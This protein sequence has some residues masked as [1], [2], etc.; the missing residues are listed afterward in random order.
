MFVLC[1]ILPILLLFWDR[2]IQYY[3]VCRER[4]S[5]Y[6]HSSDLSR[7]SWGGDLLRLTTIW[8]HYTTVLC[9]NWPCINPDPVEE[10]RGK[11]KINHW[12]KNIQRNP[13]PLQKRNTEKRWMEDTNK[14]YGTTNGKR[15]RN[16]CTRLTCTPTHTDTVNVILRC[17][18]TH[19]GKGKCNV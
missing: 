4:W 16:V 8:N 1:P 12:L 7:T 18:S 3:R 10:Y 17:I 11:Q 15:K 14:H 6:I 2:Q 5:L 19:Q 13:A 9:K